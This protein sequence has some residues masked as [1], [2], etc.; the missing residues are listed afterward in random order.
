MNTHYPSP[1]GLDE[2]AGAAHLSAHHFLR[3][4]KAAHGLT[5]SAYLNRK[6]VRAALRLMK[7][8]SWSLTRIAYHVGFGSRTTL[9]RH[10][11]AAG[12]PQGRASS[13]RLNGV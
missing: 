7:D 3:A 8:S 13:T 10:L 1:I 5:P 11:R 12:S 2:I 6:R 9:Y 4:F